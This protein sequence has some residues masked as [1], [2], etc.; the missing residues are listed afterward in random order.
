MAKKRGTS[1]MNV[2]KTKQFLVIMNKA[3]KMTG[4]Q[5]IG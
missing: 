5:E 4:F 1:L 3:E 2:P